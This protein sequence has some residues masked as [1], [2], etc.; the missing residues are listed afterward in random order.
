[1]KVLEMI[2]AGSL[3]IGGGGAGI[4]AAYAQNYIDYRARYPNLSETQ[5][6]SIRLCDRLGDRMNDALVYK[7]SN[8]QR[9]Y[10]K[11]LP[12]DA[13]LDL[14][15]SGIE[16]KVNLRVE[17]LPDRIRILM[18]VAKE[19]M[20]EKLWLGDM[21]VYLIHDR[22]TRFTIDYSTVLF[23]REERSVFYSDFKQAHATAKGELLIEKKADGLI[24]KILKET[25]VVG[26]M[27]LK[28][29]GKMLI[30]RNFQVWAEEKDRVME[31]ANE[32][33]RTKVFVYPLELEA[34]K[35]KFMSK[36]EEKLREVE[37]KTGED[38][39]LGVIIYYSLEKPN[40]YLPR[41]LK[42]KSKMEREGVKVYPLD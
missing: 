29:I 10:K 3:L 31:Q 36:R 19:N 35:P 34:A 13:T 27:L 22:R 30:R 14:S 24:T 38:R 8:W 41:I 40:K 28:Q 6:D 18:S 32:M 42:D 17:R 4:N 12:F 21:E 26:T 1:M 39:I 11:Y 23:N 37:V 2:L 33:T 16:K 5:I 7:I 20:H 25:G 15:L 9:Q